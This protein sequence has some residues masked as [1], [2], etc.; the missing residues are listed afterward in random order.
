[1]ASTP[2]WPSIVLLARWP[3][4][5]QTDPDTDTFLNYPVSK[6]MTLTFANGTTYVPSLA[7][8]VLPEDE[9]TTY[10][11]RVPTFHGYSFTGDAA[12]ELVY[13]GRGQQADF[14]RLV[15]LGVDLKGKIAL[16]RV[17][18]RLVLYSKFRILISFR[19]MEVHSEA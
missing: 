15:A 6:S 18:H 17:G 12:G 10:P 8:D 4:R 19:S 1:M 7:E 3:S 13:V 11:N 2:P 5:V 14:K 16:A 9:T